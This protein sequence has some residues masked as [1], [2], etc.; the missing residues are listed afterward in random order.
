MYM[1]FHSYSYSG[2]SKEMKDNPDIQKFAKNT[3]CTSVMVAQAAER[4]PSIFSK[5]GMIPLLDIVREYIK[6]VSSCDKFYT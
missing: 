1:F 6:M 5:E 3:G 2:G 4:N